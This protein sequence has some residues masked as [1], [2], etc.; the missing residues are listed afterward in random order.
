MA[1]Q[2]G[3]HLLTP[4]H[5]G[6]IEDLASTHRV[7]RGSRKAS[8]QLGVVRRVFQATSFGM[9]KLVNLDTC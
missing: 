4:A 7:P 3:T 1:T 5:P 2:P 9:S 8:F 6:L